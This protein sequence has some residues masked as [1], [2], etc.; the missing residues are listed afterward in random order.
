V[1]A[2]NKVINKLC[3]TVVNDTAKDKSPADPRIRTLGESDEA[4]QEL[5]L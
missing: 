1:H 5:Q 2:K 4:N 3:L